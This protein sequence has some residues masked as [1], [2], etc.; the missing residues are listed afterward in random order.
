MD[1]L[2]TALIV[3]GAVFL[4]GLALWE[5]RRS[6]RRARTMPLHDA[7]AP[8]AASASTL[9]A[10]RR[11]EPS[12]GEFTVP[13]PAARLDTL[14]V[15]VIHADEPLRVEV[16]E[17][18]AV[19]V[20]ASARAEPAPSGTPEILW[21]PPQTERVLSLRV[22]HADGT[23]IDGR[24][25]R[26][27][28]ES[29]GMQHGPQRI[30]HLVDARGSVLVSAANMVRP[31]SLVPGEMESQQFRGVS[32]F[33]ILPGPLPATRMLDGLVRVARSVALRNDAVVQD[34]QGAALDA[35]RLTQMRRSV[36]AYA[37][38]SGNPP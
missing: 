12:L 36:H 34:E 33:T 5:R 35:E 11:M 27:A 25:L 8:H 14:E 1:D 7:P 31:G 22:V 38:S 37:E 19:D 23:P 21:P 4:A 26:E 17:E 10:N 28:L 29:A 13:G 24:V 30:Y 20:P 18:T 32:L 2:R 16:S 9:S 15:P 3:L 6:A